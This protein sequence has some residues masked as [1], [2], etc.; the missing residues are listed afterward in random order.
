[1]Q[2]LPHLTTI[3][4]KILQDKIKKDSYNSS[5]F[6]GVDWTMDVSSAYLTASTDYFKVLSERLEAQ[7]VDGPVLVLSTANILGFQ[8]VSLSIDL[9]ESGL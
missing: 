7:D 2:V 8:N 6:T 1:M 3:Y 5:D 9:S 4:L